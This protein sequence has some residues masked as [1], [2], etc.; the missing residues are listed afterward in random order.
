[1]LWVQQLN[2]VIVWGR[3][4]ALLSLYKYLSNPFN[5]ESYPAAVC[6]NEP[7][8]IS[9]FACLFDIYRDTS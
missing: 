1:M 6:A 8:D 4:P 7:V 9:L 5:E 3:S 2:L